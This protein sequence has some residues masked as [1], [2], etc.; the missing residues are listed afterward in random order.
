MDRVN[1]AAV[2]TMVQ[3]AKDSIVTQAAGVGRE[4]RVFLHWSAGHYGQPFAD[5]HLNIDQQGEIYSE[6]NLTLVLAHTWHQNTGAIGVAMLCCAFA[7]PA[8]LGKEPPT[9]AQIETMAQIV[10]VLC[11]ELDLPCDYDHVR[12][13]AE[14]ADIDGYGPTT[15]CERWDGWF[16]KTG[17]QPGTGGD[18]IRGKAIWYQLNGIGV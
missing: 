12:T 1:L 9:D 6:G 16:W 17:E 10:A 3:T 4:P 7:T 18:I 5:Y 14:Q 11:Q 8:D 2:R 15:T 13:H